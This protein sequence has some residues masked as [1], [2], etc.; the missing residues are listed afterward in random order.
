MVILEHQGRLVILDSVMNDGKDGHIDNVAVAS[1]RMVRS[2]GKLSGHAFTLKSVT[3]DTVTLI[4]P[5]HPDKEITMSRED[6]IKSVGHLTVADT[7]KP[8]M[9]VADVQANPNK[10]VAGSAAQSNLNNTI[11][12]LVNNQTGQNTQNTQTGNQTGQAGQNVQQE[13]PVTTH[14]VRRGDNL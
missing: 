8:A 7:T 2:N 3:E 12:N 10:P 14:E 4:N 1:F 13:N 9:T 11:Q 5:W 6:F